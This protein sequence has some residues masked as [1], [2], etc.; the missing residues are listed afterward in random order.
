MPGSVSALRGVEDTRRA[1]QMSSTP[2]S[3]TYVSDVKEPAPGAAKV[4]P[5]PRIPLV[6]RDIDVKEVA[7]RGFPQLHLVAVPV[8]PDR[9]QPCSRVVH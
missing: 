1:Q 7:D 4:P 8:V 3:A 2:R 5:I 6:Y 9:Q